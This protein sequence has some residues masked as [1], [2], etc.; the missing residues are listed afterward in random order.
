MVV[1]ELCDESKRATCN[2][3]PEAINRYVDKAYILLLENKSLFIH[4]NPATQDD[5][6]MRETE[7]SWFALNTVVRTD[8]VMRIEFTNVSYMAQN[9]GFGSEVLEQIIKT[10]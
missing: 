6:F 8:F 7:I 3:D 9:W 1:F 4:E 2:K 5:M 10:V